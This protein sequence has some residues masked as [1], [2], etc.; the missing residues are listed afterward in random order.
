M[1]ELINLDKKIISETRKWIVLIIR[2]YE[3]K[4]LEEIIRLFKKTIFEIN[5]ADYDLAQVE[6][7]SKVDKLSFND[8]L[9]ATNSRIVVNQDEIVG[10]GNI[11]DRGYIDLF[12][13]SADYPSTIIGILTILLMIFYPKSWGKKFPASL[14]AILLSTLAVLAL[15]LNVPVVGKI[16]T[17][18]IPQAHLRLTEINLQDMKTLLIPAISITVLGMTESLLC[19]AS[20]GRATNHPMDN[21]QELV[22]QGI[23]N[24]FI[25]FFGGIP[26]TAA[27]AR[28]SV[29]I[30]AGAQTRLT[31]IIHALILLLSMFLFAPFMTHI[32]LS[33]LAGV[34]IMT[35]L[36]MNEWEA[37]H[38]LFKNKLKSGMIEFFVT[39]IITVIFDLSTAILAGIIVGF[40]LFILKISQIEINSSQIEPERISQNHHEVFSEWTVIYIS[41]P[42]FFLNSSKL[43]QVI[44]AL[45][46]NTNIVLSLRGVPMIDVTSIKLLIDIYSVFHEENRQ[47]VFASMNGKLKESFRR[48]GLINLVGEE[49]I[50]P[51]VNEFLLDLVDKKN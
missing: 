11:D 40:L 10:F 48:T 30:K 50:Y 3:P 22:A 32:P 12:Y 4:D 51:S 9:L 34:L 28:T 38:F 5:I 26:A 6:A 25:P 14:L 31:G 41:G 39:M 24:I 23:G 2:N 27:I 21:N 42:L 13:I 37:I 49:A 16:P 20:A 45:P 7:W 29:A 1:S 8:N 33:A 35:A 18:L 17:T 46:T 47:I 43:K 15:K 44:D 19:G 36:R